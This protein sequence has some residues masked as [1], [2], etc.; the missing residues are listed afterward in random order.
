MFPRQPEP[1]QA[2]GGGRNVDIN[3]P[4]A[5]VSGS[6]VLLAREQERGELAQPC[7]HNL[8]ALSTSAL[9]FTSV[10]DE[11]CAKCLISSTCCSILNTPYLNVYQIRPLRCQCHEMFLIQMPHVDT[12][13]NETL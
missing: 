6:L 12:V 10:V 4:A 9:A 13:L 7:T 5:G 3:W 8:A 1:V 11:G 2:G